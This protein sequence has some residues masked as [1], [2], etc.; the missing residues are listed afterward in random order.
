[1][2]TKQT[3]NKK[4]KKRKQQQAKPK[5]TNGSVLDVFGVALARNVSDLTCVP[6]CMRTA[7]LPVAQ[8]YT[9][10][11]A[12]FSLSSQKQRYICLRCR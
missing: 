10:I 7:G 8:H 1:M 11:I 12:S 6:A 4:N 2:K 5:E 3:N 9:I